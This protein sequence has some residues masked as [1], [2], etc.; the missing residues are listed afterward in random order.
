MDAKKKDIN[1]KLKKKYKG[2]LKIVNK[3]KK[4]Q[5]SIE[6]KKN[7]SD[8]VIKNNFKHNSAKKNVKKVLKKILLNA[9]NYIRYINNRSFNWSKS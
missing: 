5:L 9:W 7:K 3:L 4:F 6:R 1:K 2:N 8:F